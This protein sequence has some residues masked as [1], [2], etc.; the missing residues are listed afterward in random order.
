VLLRGVNSDASILAALSVA[1]L[2]IRVRPYYLFQ[3][4]PVVG[5]ERF[6]TPVAAGLEL[7][8]RL[9]GRVSGL[10]IPT[11]A[12]DAPG[13]FGKVA[14]APAGIV[15]TGPGEVRVRT[16]QGDVVA[17]PDTGEADLTCRPWP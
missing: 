13:G 4:D 12:L 2:R 9:R 17:Y 3:L 15:S 8:A 5:T 14:V 1:L 7:V 16:W 11:F 6:R 10:G